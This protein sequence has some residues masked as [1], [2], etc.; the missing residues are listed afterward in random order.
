MANTKEITIALCT[1]CSR[2]KNENLL[3][4]LTHSSFLLVFGVRDG[5]REVSDYCLALV[6]NTQTII[7]MPLR[8]RAIH[9]IFAI[10]AAKPIF[11]AM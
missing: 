7:N 3:A 5:G 1:S 11:V 10:T 4:L 6:K 2:A 8:D 9:F